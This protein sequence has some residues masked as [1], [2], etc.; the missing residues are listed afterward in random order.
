MR[1]CTRLRV[2]FYLHVIESR[3][4]HRKS[5]KFILS[6]KDKQKEDLKKEKRF[7]KSQ[8]TGKVSNHLAGYRICFDLLDDYRW[9][10]NRDET[11][12]FLFF[13]LSIV[14]LVHIQESQWT[15]K[16]DIK[17]MEIWCNWKEKDNKKGIFF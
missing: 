17:L 16:T 5:T 14:C 10:M 15:N 8:W 12:S 7:C 3:W 13:C 9:F 4:Y 6:C 1:V 11:I 2:S